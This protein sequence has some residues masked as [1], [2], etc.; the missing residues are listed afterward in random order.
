[1]AES[2]LN[3]I[4]AMMAERKAPAL[5]GGWYYFRWSSALRDR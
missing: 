5:R 2:P 3:A 1:M 4:F